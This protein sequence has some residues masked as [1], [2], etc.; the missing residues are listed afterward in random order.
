[1]KRFYKLSILLMAILFTGSQLFS[2]NNIA[3]TYYYQGNVLAPLPNIHIEL[4]DLSDSLVAITNTDDEGN[5]S[6]NEIPDGEYYISSST[7]M[8]SSD[9]T[10]TDAY[11][12]LLNI[13]DFVIFDDMEIEVADVDND[14]VVTFSDFLDIVYYIVYTQPFTGGEWEFED[15]SID[16]SSR[17]YDSIN[18]WGSSH[19][20]VEGEWEPIGRDIE[21]MPSK[22][23]SAQ[24]MEQGIGIKY[25]IGSEFNEDINGFN[26]NI[27]YASNEI[28]IV[29]LSG[30]DENVIYSI[31][32]ENGLIKVAWLNESQATSNIVGS[33]LF[34]IEVVKLNE[35]T[36]ISGQE[37][38]TM[39]PGSAL[40][41]SENNEIS[42]IEIK[43]PLL[44]DKQTMSV[45]VDIYPNPV[46]NRLN[47]NINSSKHSQASLSVYD[48]NGK[49]VNYIDG[50]SVHE[51]EQSITMNVEN[52]LP[53]NYVYSLELKSDDAK[54]VKKG[55][56]V[57][58]N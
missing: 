37:L 26:L 53:G 39:L 51:G 2:Q 56:F 16:L 47:F 19:G 4:F 24:P 45:E 20:D 10:I 8:L 21:L 7:E 33:E 38:I 58:S 32:D 31:D 5:Y 22:Y 17:A 42:D 27:A 6:L 11:M 44:Q 13:Y 40:L 49:L 43:L 28:S 54:N 55:R 35:I 9:V 3:G 14:G 29:S 57:K 41:D 34:T 50:M 15:V 1:M 23:Y 18:P 25:I 30:P 46:L 52:L 36:A 48:L 12:V